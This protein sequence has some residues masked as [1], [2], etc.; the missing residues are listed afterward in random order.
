MMGATQGVMMDA[1][2]VTAR[3]EAH[4][5]ECEIIVRGSGDQYDLTVIG[6]VFEGMRAVKKQQL[7][8]AA[9]TSQ[10]AE[11]SIHAVNIATFTPQEWLEHSRG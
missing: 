5:D 8:Y 2:Q 10:I 4:L 1:A 7:V 9:L 3:L 6:A 11:G